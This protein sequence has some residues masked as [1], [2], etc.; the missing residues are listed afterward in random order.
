MRFKR[1]TL[2]E[3]LDEVTPLLYLHY[4]EI[5]ADL[6]IPL[7]PDLVQYRT[8]EEQ[9]ALRVFTVREEDGSLVGYN[10][11]FLRNNLHYKSSLQA[12]QD[13]IFIHPEKR[14]C[15]ARFIAWCDQQ[16]KA[17]KVQSVYH[18]VKAKHNFGP[19]LERMG[20]EL[21]DLIYRKRLDKE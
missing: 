2:A 1:E 11:L 13:I 21:V 18:H 6:D 7:E 15:G 14:G 8:I 4:K 20:Y 10:I 9:G 16:L 5:S 12:L 3:V 19:M 17:E